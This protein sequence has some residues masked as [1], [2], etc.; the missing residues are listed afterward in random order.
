MAAWCEFSCNIPE[1]GR[2]LRLHSRTLAV[3]AS[4][5]ARSICDAF[6]MHLWCVCDAFVMCIILYHHLATRLSVSGFPYDDRNRGK[7]Q[8]FKKEGGRYNGNLISHGWELVMNKRIPPLVSKWLMRC[9]NMFWVIT[10]FV[11]SMYWSEPLNKIA[12]TF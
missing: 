8:H 2:I 6:V 12:Q 5:V 3:L 7:L 1:T 10:R 11:Q 4:R 9:Y